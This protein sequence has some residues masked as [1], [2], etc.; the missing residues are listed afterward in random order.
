MAA[1]PDNKLIL[2]EIK[3]HYGFKND[4]EFASFLGIMPNT[5]SN[6]HRRNTMDHQLVITKCEEISGNWLLTGKGSMLKNPKAEIPL[7]SDFPLLGKR[8]SKYLERKGLSG[9][10]AANLLGETDGQ[11]S[12][13]LKGQN[14]YCDKMYNILNLFKDLDANFLFRGS[15]TMVIGSA[16]PEKTSEDPE[17]S[18]TL[19]SAQQELIKYKDEEIKNL[20]K[21]ITTLK[22]EYKQGD[23]HLRVAES[24][25]KLK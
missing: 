17:I 13:I 15:G 1:E 12:S 10:K 24:D 19:I 22:K 21:E 14:F 23:T 6:W 11:I 2:N 7:D 5:L 8:F 25:P 4:R 3:L 9:N 18:K 20:K 16:E